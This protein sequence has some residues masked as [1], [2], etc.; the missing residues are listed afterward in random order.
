MKKNEIQTVKKKDISTDLIEASWTALSKET[1]AAY[2]SDLKL[3][4]AFVGKDFQSVTVSD[5]SNYILHLRNLKQTNAT[6]NRKIAS[7][8][9]LFSVYQKAGV[10]QQNPVEL[11]RSVQKISFKVAKGVHNQ[12]SIKEIKAAT[13]P[14]KSD[15]PI[16][17]RTMVIIKTLAE[18]GMRIS[19]LINM[20]RKNLEALDNSAY[21]RIRIIGKGQK[22]RYIFISKS[23]LSEI[24]AVFPD[25]KNPLLFYSVNGHPYDR[26]NLW[27]FIKDHFQNRIGKEDVHPHM[28][29]HFFA[30]HKI[31]NEKKDIKA[32]SRYLGHHSAQVTLDM[33]DDT[34]LNEHTAAISI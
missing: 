25:K 24:E 28:L 29:R 4:L 7:L 33:Y 20:Q 1:Q 5:V 17:I 2:K 31:A 21:Y 16:T 32:V 19:E 18:T 13:K 26:R 10:I 12:L 9:K 23:L 30:T 3:F 34:V 15:K 11:L 6:I 22:E 14:K 8:S 27:K